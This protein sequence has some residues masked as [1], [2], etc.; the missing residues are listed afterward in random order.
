MTAIA[1]LSNPQHG[2]WVATDG[3]A[4]TRDDG[5]MRSIVTKVILFPEWDCLITGRGRGGA[6]EDFRYRAQAADV[7]SFDQLIDEASGYAED[8]EEAYAK[9][10]PDEAYE[11]GAGHFSI[12]ICGFSRRREAFEIRTISTRAGSI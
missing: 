9:I 3:A 10:C 6:A 1:I 11:A 8:A 7:S 5:V 12:V 2:M 4:Y